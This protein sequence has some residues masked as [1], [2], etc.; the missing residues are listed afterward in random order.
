MFCSPSAERTLTSARIE[1]VAVM[2]EY[3]VSNADE[4]SFPDSG[5]SAVSSSES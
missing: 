3:E 4:V 1:P 2:Y 5:Q